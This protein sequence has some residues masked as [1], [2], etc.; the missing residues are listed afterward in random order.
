M[1]AS[2]KTESNA[3]RTYVR[4]FTELMAKLPNFLGGGWRPGLALKKRWALAS[5]PNNKGPTMG[6]A[7]MDHPFSDALPV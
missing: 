3:G 7:K 2:S 5:S 6:T 4:A 1:E